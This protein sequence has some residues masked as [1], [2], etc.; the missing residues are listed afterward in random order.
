MPN[1][2]GATVALWPTWTRATL[3]MIVGEIG[4]YWGHRWSH[5]VPLLWQFHAIHHS[6]EHVDWLVNTRAHPV[7]MVFTRLCGFIPLYILGLAAPLAGSAGA[8]PMLVLLLGITW[9]FFVHANLRW[10]FGPLEW[11]LATPAFHHWHHTNDGPD[12]VDKNYAP[13]LPGIDCLF[14][15][16]YL[17]KS[18]RPSRYGTDHPVPSGLFGQLLEPFM[19]QLPATPRRGTGA[20]SAICRRGQPVHGGRGTKPRPSACPH[21]GGRTPALSTL[22]PPPPVRPHAMPPMGWA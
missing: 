22:S 4:F 12:Y 2:I 16:F 18:K 9:G 6:P 8:I 1:V 17:P 20:V 19:W 5:E 7:D 3:A 11:V 21:I 14:G 13:L 10:R 15:T